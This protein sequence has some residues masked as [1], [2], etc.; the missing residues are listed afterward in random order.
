M[1]VM[2]AYPL[3]LV[4]QEMWKIIAIA[5]SLTYISSA[6]LAE[7]NV[8]KYEGVYIETKDG[9][10]ELSPLPAHYVRFKHIFYD[11]G[12]PIVNCISMECIPHSFVR[13]Y[14]VS[15]VM[16]APVVDAS[17]A[18]GIATN[19]T[20]NN[21]KGISQV[22]SFESFFGKKLSE[23]RMYLTS[24]GSLDESR[25]GAKNLIPFSFDSN[26]L[27]DA[28]WGLFAQQGGIR[29]RNIDSFNA[30]YDLADPFLD[31][32]L[33]YIPPFHLDIEDAQRGV[34][35]QIETCIKN[36]EVLL[37]MIITDN[38]LYPY[39]TKRSKIALEENFGLEK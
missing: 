21:V 14:S 12:V 11:D 20:G 7:E 34:S 37:Y 9:F 23:V 38:G 5:I 3:I 35:G 39:F 26:V 6:A 8:P 1:R 4:W 24:S 27:V 15:D 32:S 19:G 30:K 10:T 18:I 33:W 36:C 16:S 31:F 25:T 28:N 22:V 29:K 17:R 13:L 2:M